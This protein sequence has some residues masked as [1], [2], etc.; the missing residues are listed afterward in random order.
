MQTIAQ[1]NQTNLWLSLTGA[2]H[3]S[4]KSYNTGFGA[5][6]PPVLVKID[7]PGKR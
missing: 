7:D 6:L 4:C 3:L 1:K 2:L 5:D